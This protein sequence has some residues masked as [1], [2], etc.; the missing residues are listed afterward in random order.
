MKND[1]GYLNLETKTYFGTKILLRSIISSYGEGNND[2]DFLVEVLPEHTITT[3]KS[4]DIIRPK[5]DDKEVEKY[6]ENVKFYVEKE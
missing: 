1:E 3:A 5:I 6:L 2:V 4:T